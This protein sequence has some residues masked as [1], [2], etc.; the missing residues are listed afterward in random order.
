MLRKNLFMEEILWGLFVIFMGIFVPA[1]AGAADYPTKPIE[2]ISPFSPGGS[3]DIMS[4]IIS[5]NCKEYLG[6]PMVVL[7]KP[8]AGGLIGQDFVAKAKPD[9]YTL[10]A[11]GSGSVVI[12]PAVKANTPYNPVKD[13]T[14]V[15]NLIEGIN[16]ILVREGSPLDTIEKLIDYG[17]KNPGKLTYGAPLASSGHFGGEL[18]S[19][20]VGI[21]MT[22]V[23]FKGMGLSML[24]L[25]GGQI[26]L[27]FSGYIDTIEQ[28]KAG[29]LIPLAVASKQRFFDLP[30]VPTLIEK[31]YPTTSGFWVGIQ[32]PAGIPKPVLDRLSWYFEKAMSLTEVQNKFRRMGVTPTYLPPDEFAKFVQ[33]DFERCNKIAKE[34]NIK[35]E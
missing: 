8:G 28:V 32:G 17:K 26:D 7:N 18:F 27:V 12:L 23:P 6:Q 3:S 9:G 5:E 35:L 10:A 34:A 21:R 11:G 14:H 1:Q 31:G 22:H 25:L 24:A 13:F 19:R 20:D 4:R 29:K 2:L 16:L 15:C 30:Q 33:N